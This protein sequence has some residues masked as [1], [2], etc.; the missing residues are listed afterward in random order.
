MAD[1]NS[2][3]INVFVQL[4]NQ[5]IT[6]YIQKEEWLKSDI[7]TMIPTFLQKHRN[8]KIRFQRY[9]EDIIS[10]YSLTDFQ[11]HFR[12][13]KSCFEIVLNELGNV[14]IN[15][16][17]GR[18]PVPLEKNNFYVLFGYWETLKP[19][20]QSMIDMIWQNQLFIIHTVVWLVHEV[21]I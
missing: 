11:R 13:S 19:Y 16:E 12:L 1:V 7:M 9:A 2:I 21:N 18:P 3:L 5:L 14:I 10:S 8:S 15:Q 6:Q 17:K 20:V 4:Q